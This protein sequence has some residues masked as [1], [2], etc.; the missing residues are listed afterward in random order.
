MKKLKSILFNR[1]CKRFSKKVERV[2]LN[3]L[4][5]TAHLRNFLDNISDDE[6]KTTEYLETFR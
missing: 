5:E 2:K 6:A 1:L 3:F 4:Q